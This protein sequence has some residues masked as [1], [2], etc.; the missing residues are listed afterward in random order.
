MLIIFQSLFFV[1]SLAAL[2]PVFKKHA[3]KEVPISGLVLWILF[4]IGANII[5]LFPEMTNFVAN[6][7]GIGRGADFILYISVAI[8]FYLLLRVEI[9]I[10][11]Q[12]RIIT[13]LARDKAI[14]EVRKPV[15]K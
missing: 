12:N 14:A 8:L 2:S 1:F 10:E 5:V 6:V 4:W 7:F 11:R 15:R 3:K 9:S 13:Q